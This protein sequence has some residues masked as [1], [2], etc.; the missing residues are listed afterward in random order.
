MGEHRVNIGV[1]ALPELK[2]ELQEQARSEG[3]TASN[4]SERLLAWAMKQIRRAGDSQTLL[5]WTAR[6]AGRREKKRARRGQ[7]GRGIYHEV[8]VPAEDFARIARRLAERPHEGAHEQRPAVSKEDEAR[9]PGRPRR[10]AH[11]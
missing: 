7:S 6:P 1:M 9:H 2:R 11:S 3:R 4:L 8:T 10:R 5:E